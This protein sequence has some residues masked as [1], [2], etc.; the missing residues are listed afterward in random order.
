MDVLDHVLFYKLLK[1]D[2]RSRIVQYIKVLAFKGDG[3]YIIEKSVSD[4]P[5]Q[6]IS[7]NH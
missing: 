7:G 1:N 3:L 4:A 2:G 5:T 6:E